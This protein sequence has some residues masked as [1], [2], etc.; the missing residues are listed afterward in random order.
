MKASFFHNS[1]RLTRLI[2][3]R[4]RLRISLWLLIIT[5]LTMITAFAYTNLFT[6]QQEIMIY[7]ETMRNPAMTAMMGPGYGLDNYTYGAM[8]AHTMLVLTALAVAIM[9]IFLVARH[10]RRDEESGRIEMIRSLPVGRLSNLTAT[11][12][13]SFTVNILL[14][15]LTGIGLFLLG[16]ESMDLQGSLLYGASLGVAGI[17]FAAVTALFVQLTANTRNAIGYAVIFLGISYL[18]RALGDVSSE[19]LSLL[20]PLGLITRTQ[21]FVN[22][23]WWPL[24]LTVAAALAITALAFKLNSLRDL[25]A[26][27]LPARSGRKT[28][29]S[30]LKN[31]L[32]LALKLQRTSLIAWA[33][34]L[35]ILGA[36]YGSVF[37]DVDA[38]LESVEM[39]REIFIIAE[40]I[41]FVEQFIATLMS[42]IALIA[43]APALIM[44]LKVKSEEKASRIEHLLSRAVSRKQVMGSYL[45]ISLAASLIMLLLS[46]AGMWTAAAAVMADPV[47]L[48]LFLKSA[49]VYLPAIWA[50]IGLT[51]LIIGYKPGA[52]LFSWIYL[53]YSFLVIYL[54]EMLQ[55]PDWL[56]GLTPYGYVPKIP[57]EEINIPA[58]IILTIISII[59][60][61]AGFRGYRQ[62]DI[63]LSG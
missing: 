35:F 53:G 1:G 57:I 31:P 38:F 59:L 2:F 7:A 21:V 48:S 56:S 4:D 49:L 12:L 52:A 33:A 22:N 27:L 10:T 55:I 5:A 42:V 15:L 6:T 3:R 29:S 50:L 34:G 61:A 13:A 36:S 16:I 63:Q 62:R 9:N 23:Y 8:M 45:L 37:G 44:I 28:A 58:L 41:P 51:V 47:P 19:A 25:E 54:G 17:F 24:L 39:Y 18:V 46:A 40:D 14:A 30:W 20:S 26:G 43:T 32:G 11:T 60:M